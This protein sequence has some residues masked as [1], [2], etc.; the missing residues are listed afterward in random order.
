M[1]RNRSITPSMQN[2]VR[3]EAMDLL[4]SIK[5]GGAYWLDPLKR[6]CSNPEC[7]RILWAFHF[8]GDVALKC[9]PAPGEKGYHCFRLNQIQRYGTE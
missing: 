1:S 4:K 2:S 6:R 5:G 8:Q 9:R 3:Y 7:N